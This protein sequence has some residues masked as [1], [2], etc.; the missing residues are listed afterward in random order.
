MSRAAWRALRTLLRTSSSI[1][2][3][4]GVGTERLGGRPPRRVNGPQERR[5]CSYSRLANAPI[6]GRSPLTLS[7]AD[8]GEVTCVWLGADIAAGDQPQLLVQ[9]RQW[10]SALRDAFNRSFPLPLDDAG[11]NFPMTAARALSAK[12]QGLVTALALGGAYFLAA[13]LS[14]ELFRIDERLAAIWIP[15]AVA[16]AAL[17]RTPERRWPALILACMAGNL[18]ASLSAGHQ[19]VASLS[20]M[21]SNATEYVF[22]SVILVR[23]LPKPIKLDRCRDLAILTGVMMVVA[24]ISAA[25][26]GLLFWLIHTG[27]PVARVLEWS[28]SEPLI[29][30]IITPCLLV[31]TRP[32]EH[33]AERPFTWRAGMTLVLLLACVLGVF[34]QNRA[35]VLFLV[36][37]ALLL[38]AAE[39]GAFGAA[40]GVLLT[41]AV[42]IGAT[43]LHSSP[44][45]LTRG[46]GATQVDVLLLFLAVSLL[47][48]LP[49]ANLQARQRRLHARTLAEAERAARAEI[50]ASDSEARYRLFAESVNDML[51]IT[52]PA[53]ATIEFVSQ[54]SEGVLGYHPDELIGRSMLE[55]THQDDR[56]GV[57]QFFAGLVE[58]GPNGPALPYQFRARHRDGSWKWLEGQPRVQFDENGA[59]VHFQ[60]VVRDITS[61]KAMETELR[62]AHAAAEAAAEV[63]SQF[64][65]NMSHELRTP[66]TAVIGF[67]SL[68][69]ERPELSAQ[70]RQYVERVQTAGKALLAT[71]NDVLDFSKLEAGQVEIRPCL[72]DPA[73]LAMQVV[74]LFG[75]QAQDKDLLLRLE[76]SE[77]L[78]SCL[79]LDPD[80]T[81]QVLTNLV[82]NA[83]KFT[84][85]G[86][87]TVSLNYA[88]EAMVVEVSD[89]GPGIPPDRASLLFQRFSQIDGSNTRRHGGTGLGLAICKGLVEAM[90]GSIGLTSTL[91]VGSTFRFVLPAVVGDAAQVPATTKSTPDLDGRYS[92]LLAEDNPVNR[93][94]VKALLAPYP[95]D[96][97][98]V[99]NG[100]EAVRCGSERPFD[101]ILMDLHM[102]ELNGREAALALRAGGGPNAFTPIL[103][104]SADVLQP[105]LDMFD[106]LIAKPISP[107]VLLEAL[108]LHLAPA[109]G[110]HHSRE[111]KT[112]VA[113]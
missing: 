104:F 5:S 14:I 6:P 98:V 11:M 40:L 110:D 72:T 21:T 113:V 36:P 111:T 55:M 39:F 46:D 82:G 10:Q 24:W 94:L 78:P 54:A 50:A 60:D 67:T 53:D 41:A 9:P 85:W 22:G 33:L 2:T 35:P 20:M 18:L 63:K 49:V 44:I 101:L 88:D 12:S 8:Q 3:P 70:T 29:L 71:V 13:R 108:E 4:K 23:L 81:R 106:G 25:L 91:G 61:R 34:S 75:V 38:V 74:Q 112:P 7:L 16:L 69:G 105:N 99:E 86:E 83:V 90:G 107:R 19:L 66:L 1:H 87:V 79:G 59:P 31:L 96:I 68:I 56:P 65:A 27:D 102:P 45:A 97:E 73:D 32:A 58:A 62:S 76:L 80:R 17:L 42:A 48:S 77:A 47:S 57:I 52:S 15:N 26:A 37:T 64:L 100:L 43:V 95:L 109:T 89:T 28:L 103:A 30:A 93:E 92:L 51:A 84:D